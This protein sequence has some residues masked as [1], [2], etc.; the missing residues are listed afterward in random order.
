MMEDPETY[1]KFE[2]KMWA[3]IKAAACGSGLHLPRFN[4]F[5]ILG[6]KKNK[7]KRKNAL[8]IFIFKN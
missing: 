2:R 4:L 3:D 5:R 1:W 7:Y 6:L 8:T